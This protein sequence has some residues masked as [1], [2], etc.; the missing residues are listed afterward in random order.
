VTEKQ[1]LEEKKAEYANKKPSYTFYGNEEFKIENETPEIQKQ[2][3]VYCEKAN[4]PSAHEDQFYKLV[5]VDKLVS[6]IENIFYTKAFRYLGYRGC[7]TFDNLESYKEYLESAHSKMNIITL[8]GGPITD[9]V[10][11]LTYG[12][13]LK[14]KKVQ[15]IIVFTTKASE[16]FSLPYLDT[17]KEE[18]DGL[19]YSVVL[20]MKK[21]LDDFNI[22]AD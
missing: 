10:V 14:Q 11:K 22:I 13:N 19:V 21:L 18:I 17:R 6:S 16:N 5:W 15:K 1:K 20:T 2:I 9:S 7:I 3:I 12:L 8:T 4:M